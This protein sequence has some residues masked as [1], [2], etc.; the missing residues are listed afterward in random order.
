M[1]VKFKGLTS[2]HQGFQMGYMSQ[3]H[4]GVILSFGAE[5]KWILHLKLNSVLHHTT[6]GRKI[7]PSM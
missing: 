6:Y 1:L 2:L 4:F 3:N 7:N 5:K